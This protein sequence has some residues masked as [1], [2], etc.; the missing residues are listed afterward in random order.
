MHG[1]LTLTGLMAVAC[2][3]L[4][5]GFLVGPIHAQD[6]T[7]DWPTYNRDASR[8][9]VSRPAWPGPDPRDFYN[10]PG[11][12][13]HDRLDLDTVFQLAAA[14][15]SVWFGS[16]IE[17]SL[18]CLD[19]VTGKVQWLCTADGPVR[20]APHVVG[21][22]IYFASDD[23]CVYCVARADGALIWKYRAAP[24]DYQVPSD[25][26]LVSLWPNRTGVIVRDGILYCGVGVFPS[27][28]VYICALNADTGADSGPGLFRLRFTDVS[29]QGYVL[30][31]ES[32]LYFPGGRSGPWVFERNTGKRL[33]QFGGGGGTYAVVTS[34]QSLIYGPGRNAAVLAEFD[35]TSRD[36]LASFPGAR[37]IVVTPERSY[38][39]A[40]GELISF[41]RARYVKLTREMRGLEAKRKDLDKKS[42]EYAK[43]TEGINRAGHAQD[44]CF[45]WRV[46]C[47][48]EDGLILAGDALIVG[49]SD[50][51]AAFQASDGKAIWEQEV[52]G[53]AKGLAVAK[54]RLLVSTDASRIYCFE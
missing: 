4:I 20:F 14:G 41:D 42:E 45:V 1:R 36:H 19:A 3:A 35:G 2:L 17:D 11:V 6:A 43:L 27:E 51:V 16:S 31:S 9:A 49:G 32:K 8:S 7:A 38:I 52:E 40:R 23:G 34:D 46:P 28:G 39:V 54:G 25:G 22:R 47:E 30:A 37:H 53:V 18:K 24:S 10:S 33:G 15:D 26:K 21:D 29:L 48:Y 12:D 50:T 5:A 13:N 44:D